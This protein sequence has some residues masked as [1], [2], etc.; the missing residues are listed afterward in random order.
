MNVL[1]TVTNEELPN[2]ICVFRI[3]KEQELQIHVVR[4]EGSPS[5]NMY[6]GQQKLSLKNPKGTQ[7]EPRAYAL[8]KI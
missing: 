4:K 1:H 8:K 5:F 7:R 6:S 2:C 3:Y